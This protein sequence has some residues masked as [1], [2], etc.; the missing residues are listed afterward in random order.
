MAS[1]LQKGVVNFA[2]MRSHDSQLFVDIL[3]SARTPSPNIGLVF[4]PTLSGPLGLVLEM[5]ALKQEFSSKNE[6]EGVKIYLIGMDLAVKA[7]HPALV[8]VARPDV[9]ITKSIVSYINQCRPGIKHTVCFVPRRSLLCDQ[10][11][12]EDPVAR[13]SIARITEFPL[14]LIPFDDD[15]LSMEAIADMR[16]TRVEGDPTVL[17]NAARALMK[18]QA[19]YGTIPH[20]FGKGNYAKQLCDILLRMRKEAMSDEGSGD[21]DGIGPLAAPDDV[22][23]EIGNLVIIDREVDMVT[24]M[25]T[26]LSFEGAI[27]EVFGISNSS[28]ELDAEVISPPPAPGTQTDKPAR[29][30]RPGQKLRYALT[31]NDPLYYEMRHLNCL[32]IGKFLSQRARELSAIEQSRKNMTNLNAIKEFMSKMAMLQQEKNSIRIFA[33]ILEKVQA[34]HDARLHKRVET[35]QTLICAE[36]DEV[37]F[38]EDCILRGDPFEDVLRLLIIQAQTRGGFKPKIADQLKHEIIQTYGYEALYT[39]ER[40]EKLGLLFR[41]QTRTS[42][43]SV[44]RSL[45]LMPDDID[46]GTLVPTDPACAYS[47]FAPIVSRI[48]EAVG[49]IGGWKTIEDSLKALPGGPVFD[50]EQIPCAK[51]PPV[52]LVFVIGG[53]TYGELSAL[54]ILS[55]V[56]GGNRNDYIV[57]T[58]KVVTG[59]SLIRSLIDKFPS[60]NE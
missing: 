60:A 39:L 36:D 32:A 6:R 29:V 2:T 33:H 34:S 48:A 44:L 57:A 30:F 53:I 3:R 54:R 28:I 59:S 9:E 12:N 24:P 14:Y 49:R 27:D 40:F 22:P 35:E 15:L 46:E 56:E 52:T 16:T 26:Q 17:F 31:S 4:D 21:V 51:K 1:T 50:V 19:A 43:S 10:I 41:T 38:I 55:R 8:W 23:P 45:R 18:L 5:P 47:G 11:L 42:F 7:D 58:T 25:M 13:S 20:I 37:E